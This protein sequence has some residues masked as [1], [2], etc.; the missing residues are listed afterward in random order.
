MHTRPA[1]LI[2]SLL[3][4][5]TSAAVAAAA[6]AEKEI[7]YNDRNPLWDY[8]KV[9]VRPTPIEQALSLPPDLAKLKIKAELNVE[10]VVNKDGAVEFA[11]IVKSTEPRFNVSILAGVRNWKFKPAQKDGE[12]VNCR[13]AQALTVE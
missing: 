12:P 11:R 2:L 1:R 4:L 10:Y 13:V 9:D 3:L 8:T 7:R 5:A 6:P